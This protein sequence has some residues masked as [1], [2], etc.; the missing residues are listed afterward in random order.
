MDRRGYATR[1][2]GRLGPPGGVQQRAGRCRSPRPTNPDL[3]GECRD[4]DRTHR[5]L[6][7]K[8]GTT[9]HHPQPLRMNLGPGIRR[10]GRWLRTPS[11]QGG[12]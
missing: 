3:P 11:A 4:P 9:S 5:R 8:L 12:A 10:G 2:R 6:S 1:R 7:A